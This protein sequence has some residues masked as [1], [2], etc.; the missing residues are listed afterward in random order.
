MAANTA[1]TGSGSNWAM[2]AL[3]GGVAVAAL[4]WGAGWLSARAAGDPAPHGHPWAGISA[5]AH[6]DDPSIAWGSPVGPP[7]LYWSVLGF[8]V[9]VAVVIGVSIW[10]LGHR[11]G[12]GGDEDPT[13]IEGLASRR[14][15]ESAAGARGLV[16]RAET[17][18]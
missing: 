7:T 15:V 17:L 4:C 1:P 14:Q 8:V 10:R 13:R 12:R 9:V 3:A 11:S 16:G 18:R 5:F 2:I 6:A